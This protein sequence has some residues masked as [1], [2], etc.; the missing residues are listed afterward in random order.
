MSFRPLREDEEIVKP[1]FRPLDP[2]EQVVE[3][4]SILPP[5]DPA[6]FEQ[7]QEPY[8]QNT[9]KQLPARA[10]G[11]AGGLLQ[12]G[13][14]SLRGPELPAGI[15]Q[16]PSL[17][18]PVADVMQRTGDVLADTSK[19]DNPPVQAVAEAVKQGRYWDA[20]KGVP[21]AALPA[22]FQS[23][24]D[25]AMM[26]RGAMPL[27]MESMG[28]AMEQEFL[29]KGGEEGLRSYLQSRGGAAVMAA[30][31]RFS[32][33]KILGGLGKGVAPGAVRGVAAETPA[34]A[35]QEV[36]EYLA[37]TF[38]TNEEVT[39][40]AMM[41]AGITG[42]LVAAGPGAIMGGAVG[43]IEASQE[44]A[45]KA[46]IEEAIKQLLLEDMR[47]RRP[48]DEFLI[49]SAGRTRRGNEPDIDLATDP[50]AAPDAILPAGPA[51]AQRNPFEDLPPEAMDFL[52]D[53]LG[54]TREQLLEAG[55][56]ADPQ[57]AQAIIDMILSDDVVDAITPVQ[58]T[59][60]GE[61]M[62]PA[63]RRETSE[64][65]ARQRQAEEEMGLTPDVQAA[66]AR[67]RAQ[68]T[69]PQTPDALPPPG[70][71]VVV[72][73]AGRAGTP[74]EMDAVR[75]E[76][77]ITPEDDL[78][79]TPDIEK[80]ILRRRA[81]EAMAA[82]AQGEEFARDD[83]S[84]TPKTLDRIENQRKMDA[85]EI[86]KPDTDRR[87]EDVGP[88]EG[89]QERR[90]GD[91]RQDT[92]TKKRIED[93]TLEEAQAELGRNPVT[94]LPSRRAYDGA[95]KMPVQASVDVDSLKW[96]NDNMGGHAA[97]DQLLQAVADAMAAETDQ[98]YH[99]SGD[100][101]AVQGMTEEEV[102][103]IMER[104][105]AR[106]AN[107]TI[108]AELPDGTVVELKGLGVTHSTG[109]TYEDADSRLTAAK[110]RATQEGR[111]AGREQQ[112]PGATITPPVQQ[113][114]GSPERQQDTERDVAETGESTLNGIPPAAIA[115]TMVEVDQM[116]GDKV[117]RVRV[118]ASEALK[119]IRRERR[120]FKLL[121]DCLRGG[122]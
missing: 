75:R 27:W 1:R 90:Q 120:A 89:E 97:G 35:T 93:L 83:D 7:K 28:E 2:S 55:R 119:D 48:E 57:D 112:P 86:R 50:L 13:A 99:F 32:L 110:E 96:V 17:L 116:V 12:S 56:T 62:T 6:Y 11:L 105:K 3:P 10:A 118:R 101:F 106:L 21:A 39:L 69:P 8:W 37:T 18:N 82:R 98:A 42:G 94:G 74:A 30:L 104:V 92:A 52:Q 33:D 24:P 64:W 114:R 14:R 9:L 22:L 84:V 121:A 100:E 67:R 29:D 65:Q 73:S 77:Q 34:E 26:F 45:E 19:I 70:S 58:V 111:R 15:P 31:N 103:A 59:P 53:A 36:V 102:E 72:D 115:K 54:L 95:E 88:P 81:Q 113:S 85:L 109:T 68:E 78:G 61:A 25:M 43:G 117:E 108:R 63:Q 122:K 71:E 16:P 91:R 80:E 51:I 44:Q 66:G 60:E 46:Q 40:K 49:D 23:I 41:D 76:D 107:A 47:A 79:I 5:L 87:T 4:G 20:V 38:G